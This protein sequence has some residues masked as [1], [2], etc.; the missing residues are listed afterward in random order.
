MMTVQDDDSTVAERHTHNH[1]T[2]T[3]K[4][5]IGKQFMVINLLL[6]DSL[7]CD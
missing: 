7:V 3:G 4:R 2:P 5:F 6:S 1:L